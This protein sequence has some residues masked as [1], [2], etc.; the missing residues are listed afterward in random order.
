M[1]SCLQL[2]LVFSL[3]GVSK[4][5]DSAKTFLLDSSAFFNLQV[6]NFVVLGDF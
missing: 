6:K 4:V 5:R 1:Q 3:A 2:C